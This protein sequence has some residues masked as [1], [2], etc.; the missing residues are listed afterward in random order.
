MFNDNPDAKW[1]REFEGLGV[2]QVRG[3]AMSKGWEREKR[4]AARRWLERQDTKAWQERRKEAPDKVP[5][6]RR[7]RE[8]K[9]WMYVVGGL[10]LGFG[11]LR[12]FRFF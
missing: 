7:L 11:A 12:L 8:S 3:A 1:F 9:W 4:Q 6:R 5:W 10:L 2:S